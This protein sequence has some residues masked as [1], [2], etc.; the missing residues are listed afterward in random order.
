MFSFADGRNRDHRDCDVLMIS[1]IVVE[2]KIK[3][4]FLITCFLVFTENIV[5][6]DKSSMIDNNYS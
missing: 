6:N 5:S 2:L 4:M 1:W 3:I